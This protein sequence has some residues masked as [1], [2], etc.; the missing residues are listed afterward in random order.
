MIIGISGKIKSGKNT[1]ASII[2]DLTSKKFEEKMFAS[3]LKDIICILIGCTREQLESQDFKAK[4]LGEEWRRWYGKSYGN[5]ITPYYDNE[6]AV[7]TSLK[8]RNLYGEITSELLTPRLLLQLIGTDLFRDQLHPQIWAN[9]L[10]NQYQETED[11][12]GGAGHTGYPTYS[13]PSWIITDMRFPNEFTAVK[14]RGGITIRVNRNNGTRAIDVNPHPSETALDN[15]T[16]DYEI[17]ND[18]TID[19]LIEKIK[20]ILTKE[21][22]L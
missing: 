16:F 20:V 17:E 2:N 8:F 6:E 5:R 7:K 13:Y 3:S 1:V 19:E 11:Y 22:L 4:E 9:S 18:G 14:Q 21:N 10:M 12:V 15:A